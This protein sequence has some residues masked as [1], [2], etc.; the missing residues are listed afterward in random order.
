TE[1]ATAV[2]A[3]PHD[4]VPGR[5]AGEEPAPERLVHHGEVD[6][7]GKPDFGRRR[8]RAESNRQQERHQARCKS[9]SRSRKERHAS[10]TQRPGP[11]ARPGPPP[12]DPAASY[13][14]TRRPCSTIGAGGLNGRVR[15]G[16]GC[17]PSA[18]ATGNRITIWT[19]KSLESKCMVAHARRKFMVKPHGHL[20]PVSSTPYG[21]STPGLST[22]SSSRGLQGPCGPEMP[23]LGVGF[24]LICFQR[25]SR[26]HI[27]TRRCG[28]RH[29][30]ITSG[31][32]I[33]V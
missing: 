16:N 2:A 6:G 32:S 12:R 28:W 30:R 7:D 25:L 3:V 26:P 23:Y 11:V 22:S 10:E 13:S 18:I 5:I 19:G 9:A 31:A 21:A 14:P 8:G 24:P 17:F 33:P 1:G 20:V 4:A 15:D 27:A 29:N